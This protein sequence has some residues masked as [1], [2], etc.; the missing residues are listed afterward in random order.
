MAA[1]PSPVLALALVLFASVAGAQDTYSIFN[2]GHPVVA[3]S[4]PDGGR[5]QFGFSIAFHTTD[6][7]VHV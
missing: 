2:S 6:A 4:G 5:S 7:G 1:C 3:T